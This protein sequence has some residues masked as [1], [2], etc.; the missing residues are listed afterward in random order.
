MKRSH[1]MKMPADGVRAL[2]ESYDTIY[3]SNIA[4]GFRLMA[5]SG[6]WHLP[7]GKMRCRF[8]YRKAHDTPKV[9]GSNVR[10]EVTIATIITVAKP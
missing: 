2:A 5:S 3:A 6:V 8:V 4:D 1:K 9:G 7:N 10:T